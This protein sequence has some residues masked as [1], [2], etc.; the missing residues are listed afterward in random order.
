MNQPLTS[1]CNECPFLVKFKHAFSITRLTELALINDFHCH[2]TGE[3]FENEEG[4][5]EFFPNEKSV[6]CAGAM[7]F[8]AKRKDK[9]NYGFDD[10]KLNME[11][12]VR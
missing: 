7:I 3:T 6:L 8:L 2:K 11:A 5:D 1:P 10:T 12:A 4:P 9:F